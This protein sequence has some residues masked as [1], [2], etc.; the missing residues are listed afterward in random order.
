MTQQPVPIEQAAAILGTTF[1]AIRKRIK[2][3]TLT[4][5]KGDGGRWM[6][7]LPAEGE[8]TDYPEA[9]GPDQETVTEMLG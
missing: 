2:R 5:T 7:F 4:A 8:A 9:T 6:I 3:G 1:S